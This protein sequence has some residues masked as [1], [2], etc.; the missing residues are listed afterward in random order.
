MSNIENVPPGIDY[1]MYMQWLEMQKLGQDGSLPRMPDPIG[2]PND[3]VDD[4]GGWM[5]NISKGSNL[6]TDL[7]YLIQN[8][9]LDYGA[10]DPI[11][12]YEAVDAPGRRRLEQMMASGD[13]LQMFIARGFQS[14]QDANGVMTELQK[15]LAMEDADADILR[16]RLP[17]SLDPDSPDAPDMFAVRDTLQSIESSLF[18]DPQGEM[19]DGQFMTS[20]TNDSPAREALLRAGYLN[21]PGETYDPWVFAPEGVTPESEQAIYD[22]ER[23]ADVGLYGRDNPLTGTFG[24]DKIGGAQPQMISAL[25]DLNNF[26]GVADTMAAMERLQAQQGIDAETAAGDDRPGRAAVLA[27]IEARRQRE[28]EKNQ[29][30]PN[31]YHWGLESNKEQATDMRQGVQGLVNDNY[32]QSRKMASGI[33]DPWID[34]G[35]RVWRWGNRNNEQP[36]A[37]SREEAPATEGHLAIQRAIQRGLGEQFAKK[38]RA[39]GKAQQDHISAM[40]SLNR[41]ASGMR[42]RE[43]MAQAMMEMGFSP[44]EDERRRRNDSIYGR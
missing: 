35:K 37:P 25:G 10:F 1:D 5:T 20:S 29:A 4:L 23:R 31:E 8:N 26:S 11:T 19:I 14:G 3:A 27:A 43:A 28:S 22:D 13:P 12:T 18:S 41:S 36:S 15:K 17:Q 6:G 21:M 34:A 16:S 40:T 2:L 24:G 30:M 39:A 7:D 44:F 33:M 9:L 38:D 32:N 42:Q